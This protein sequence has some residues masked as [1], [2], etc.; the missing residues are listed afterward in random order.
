MGVIFFILFL[1]GLALAV[2]LPIITFIKTEKVQLLRSVPGLLVAATFLSL[3]LSFTTIDAG[4]VGVVK[5]FGQPVR[6]LDPGAHFVI[7]Y[8]ETV[9]NVAVQTRTVTPE[10][11]ASSAD[12]QVVKTKVTL[13]YHINPEYA[14]DILVKL[15]DDAEVRIINP[16]IIEAV[17]ATTAKYNASELI[18]QRAT[19]R[20]GIETMISQR[21]A[22]YHLIADQVSITDF[23]FSEDYN[24]AIEAKVTAQQNAEKA[25]NDLQRIKTEAQQQI[26]QAK[27]EAEALKSQKEQITPE[28]LQLRTIEMMSKN[29]DGHLPTTIVG[30]NGALPMLNVLEAAREKK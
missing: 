14:T 9:T 12:L 19:V 13:A 27:G 7:P 8:A 16:S 4:S 20:D 6:Q 25:L 28:L 30:G 21:L 11:I 23:N 5:K 24:K 15:N 3:S 22:A 1:V 2:A 26:E 17:K 10:E 29:W 18:T